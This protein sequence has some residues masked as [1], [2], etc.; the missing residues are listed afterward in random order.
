MGIDILSWVFHANNV[1]VELLS[2]KYI[3]VSLYRKHLS[4]TPNCGKTT[5]R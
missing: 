2:A 5:K 3:F 1:I 4:M